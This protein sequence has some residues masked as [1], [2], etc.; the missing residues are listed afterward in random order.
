M[1]LQGVA[2][3]SGPSDTLKRRMAKGI[4]SRQVMSIP[5]LRPGEG[6]TVDLMQ[7]RVVQVNGQ[8]VQSFAIDLRSAPVPERKYLAEA[9][10]VRRRPSG[11]ALLFGQERFGKGGLRSLLV[12]QMSPTGVARYLNSMDEMN[13]SFE[14]MAR[15]AGITAEPGVE[16]LEEPAQTIA[17]GATM[18]LS[19]LSNDD[20][21]MDFFKTS[22]FSLAT[23]QQTK[24]IAM[25]PVVR[26]DL[27]TSLLL[28]LVEKLRRVAESFPKSAFPVELPEET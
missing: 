22:P 8:T 9:C 23:A 4:T 10:D 1:N 17:L 25:E 7:H 6:P 2:A 26:V 18:I 5:P 24:K 28:A 12:I 20:A 21:C 15:A 19:A 27:A 13:P 16:I 3:L 14:V 11:V